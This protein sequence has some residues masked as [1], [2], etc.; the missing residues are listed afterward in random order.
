MLWNCQVKY[1]K[2]VESA[3]EYLQEY[4]QLNYPKLVDSVDDYIQAPP[5]STPRRPP[6]IISYAVWLY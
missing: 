1:R 4:R 3:H 6:D 2:P 5:I